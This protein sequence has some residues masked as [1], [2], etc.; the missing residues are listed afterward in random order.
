MKT[1][2]KQCDCLC[3][4]NITEIIE[5]IQHVWAPS[6]AVL[7][8]TPTVATLLLLR[9]LLL[10]TSNIMFMM[11]FFIFI[12]STLLLYYKVIV[13]K[14]S[15]I[16]VTGLLMFKYRQAKSCQAPNANAQPSIGGNYH[17]FSLESTRPRKVFCLVNV[18]I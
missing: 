13:S 6:L 10:L 4:V 14:D 16:S 11:L 8:W 17:T 1:F 2:L 3:R 15:S 5:E 18:L 9:F 12:L 7:L